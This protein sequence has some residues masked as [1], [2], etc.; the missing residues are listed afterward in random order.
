ML[1]RILIAI[2]MITAAGCAGV[3]SDPSR[4]STEPSRWVKRPF[5]K[6]R[7]KTSHR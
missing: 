5:W 1:T 6:P 4:S 2:I 7:K 3:K